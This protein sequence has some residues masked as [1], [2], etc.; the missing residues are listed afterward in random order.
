MGWG[1]SSCHPTCAQ[2]FVLPSLP[3]SA[4][5]AHTA[6]LETE[7]FL[8][9]EVSK[10]KHHCELCWIINQSLISPSLLLLPAPLESSVPFQRFLSCCSGSQELQK[11]KKLQGKFC[12][13][14]SI[15]KGGFETLC[16][17]PLP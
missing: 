5:S 10:E 15:L 16:M 1:C 3:P 4:V 6:A 14:Q 2:G 11:L 13:A 12:P 7:F 17:N 9:P 8:E